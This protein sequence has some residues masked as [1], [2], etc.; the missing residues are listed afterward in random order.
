MKS[1][2]GRSL[3]LVS[4]VAITGSGTSLAQ[5]FFR[6]FGSSR[7]SG[8]IGPVVPSEYTYTDATPSGLEAVKP[9]EESEY[10]EKY[11]FAIGPVR[12]SLA[13]GAGIEWND[14][15]NLA[16]KDRQ[17]D[18]VFRPS[19]NIDGS[20][21][22]SQ[23]NTL[24]F[25]LGISYAKY[26]D[27][28]EL[29]SKAPLLSPTSEIAFSFEV[30]AFKVTMRERGSYAEDTYNVSQ[31]GGVAK[32]RRA[33]NQAGIEFDWALNQNT[34][35]V[36]GYDHYNLWTFDKE[37]SA[38]ERA[39]DTVFLKPEFQLTPTVKVGA[40]ATYS[41]IDFNESSRSD[42]H[43]ILIGPFFEWKVAEFITAYLEAG[44]QKLQ[45]DGTSQFDADFFRDLTAE[46]RRL[47]RDDENSTSWY[48][49]FELEHR[50]ND[51]FTH[52][53]SGSKTSE[54]GIG[55]DFYDLYHI[56]YSA[57]WTNFIANTQFSPTLFYEYYE[58]S[59]PL[60]EH[61]DRFGAAIGIR[62]NL[63]NS[64][65]L[66]LDYRFLIKNSNLKDA[67]FYQ[68]LAFLSIYYKF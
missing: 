9:P 15:V 35:L 57:D 14:N 60:G 19:L 38:D 13:A 63:T 61:A 58:S 51:Y 20:W 16:N 39:V 21:K 65:T 27:H 62:H 45:F 28:T 41:W 33:E 24:R 50:A 48:V 7:S 31:L 68:N 8:G 54:I 5:D 34:T 37:F 44:L 4:A 67:D 1:S 11:N 30:G 55:T 66:G 32:Y 3:S 18:F 59:G 52:K 49:K 22:V 64:I 12:F 23:L 29:D 6:D 36:F 43:N 17:S 10:Q 42:G 26:F 56:E 2:I 53:L 40:V 46:E 25:G 47:F